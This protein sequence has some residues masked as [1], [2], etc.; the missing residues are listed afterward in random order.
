ML[1]KGFV[2]AHLRMF[3]KDD[4]EY[5]TTLYKDDVSCSFFRYMKIKTFL[6]FYDLLSLNF[7]F[8][9]YAIPQ[10]IEIHTDCIKIFDHFGGL[11]NE[12][13]ES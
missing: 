9:I 1:S 7:Y 8:R 2:E 12:Y 3:L 10:F 4:E 11:L 5:G 13:R 6:A